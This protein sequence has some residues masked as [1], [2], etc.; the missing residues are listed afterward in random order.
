[1]LAAV[2]AMAVP[3]HGGRSGRRWVRRS[4]Y[5][6]VEVVTHPD[7]MV[8]L[9]LDGSRQ[10]AWYPDVPERA[11][12]GYV[13]GLLD[14]VGRAPLASKGTGRVV[15]IGLGGGTVCR[16]VR[17]R[18]PAMEV[19]AVELDPMVV[20]AARRF[21]A[22]DDGVQV[23]VGDGRAWLDEA[24]GRWDLVVLD[25]ASEDYVPPSLQTVECLQQVRRLLSHDG[26]VLANGWKYAP[27]A[28]SEAATWR[29]VFPGATERGVGAGEENRLFAA[30]PGWRPG[31]EDRAV[32]GDD[33][34][35]LT[36]ADG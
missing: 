17:R 3:A 22:L 32:V 9:L 29:S 19:H 14:G 27:N 35:L 34:P 8:E 24:S 26:V 21:F 18:W 2:A 36:D 5:N 30:G 28:A 10:S 13:R 6:T 11:V 31:P 23:H 4:P 25:A 33:A 15:V 12:Y 1:M 7:G 20:R 16:E